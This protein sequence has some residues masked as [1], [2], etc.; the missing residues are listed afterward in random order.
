M[1]FSRGGRSFCGFASARRGGGMSVGFGVSAV[2][3]AIGVL[4]LCFAG[5]R[6]T[7]AVGGAVGVAAT[8]AAAEGVGMKP[9]RPFTH[10]PTIWPKLSTC[11]A[12]PPVGAAPR[13]WLAMLLSKSLLCVGP[14]P[15][16]PVPGREDR[17][18]A[19]VVVD[20]ATTGRLDANAIEGAARI[21]GPMRSCEGR[22]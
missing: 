14:V 8:A 6:A 19:A 3:T 10:P 15:V 5:R 20:A 13:C 16:I 21:D 1:T 22:D 11:P 9:Q 18:A 4:D 12:F 2:A 7:A 17:P